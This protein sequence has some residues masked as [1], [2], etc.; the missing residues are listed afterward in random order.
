[1]YLLNDESRYYKKDY[2]EEHKETEA[3]DEDP[4]KADKAGGEEKQGEGD[5]L[6]EGGE[7]KEKK[8]YD[9][10]EFVRPALF[11]RFVQCKVVSL[12]LIFAFWALAIMLSI[13]LG[14]LSGIEYK[15]DERK[16]DAMKR[17]ILLTPD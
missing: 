11:D 8:K 15:E 9:P 6:V 7:K 17:F 5:A 14:T 4:E 12:I 1:M 16:A 13:E 2:D 3:G 10:E